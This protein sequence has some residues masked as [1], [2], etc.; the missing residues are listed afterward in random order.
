MFT[1]S[2]W[3]LPRPIAANS[4]RLCTRADMRL[5][6]AITWVTCA[7][8]SL[9]GSRSGSAISLKLRMDRIGALRSWAATWAKLSR[10]SFRSASDATSAAVDCWR[11]RSF[12]SSSVMRSMFAR[13]AVICSWLSVMST[14][15]V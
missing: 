11:S 13:R 14:V 5:E 8:A 2:N 10:S 6:E 3:A 1:D 12:C 15:V 4:R 9:A 7:Y